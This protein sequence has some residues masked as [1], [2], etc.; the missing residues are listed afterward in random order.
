MA[1]E[2][3]ADEP[4]D[5]AAAAAS[6]AITAYRP[7]EAGSPAPRTLDA[8]LAWAAGLGVTVPDWAEVRVAGEGYEPEIRG[9][10][11]PA[12]YFR[13]VA[14]S[15]GQ[16]VYWS[17][18]PGGVGGPLSVVDP[19]AG[20]VLIVFRRSALSSDEQ[21]LHV[22]AHE[23]FEASR[24]REEFHAVLGKRLTAAAVDE[25]T[26]AERGLNNLHAEAWDYADALLRRFRGSD[27]ESPTP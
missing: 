7:N 14:S 17:A 16:W 25:L 9:R 24:L 6:S 18:P 4:P 22:L 1:G 10:P 20:R 12:V 21:F 19:Q 15:P 11:V 3:L 27:A 13:A 23:V 5:L 26:R 8:L 2:E